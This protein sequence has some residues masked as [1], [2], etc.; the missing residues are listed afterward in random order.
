MKE[1][2]ENIKKD[3]E[4]NRRYW[5][6]LGTAFTTA[7]VSHKITKEKYKS[8]NQGLSDGIKIAEACRELEDGDAHVKRVIF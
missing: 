3:F 1:F 6:L 7:V 5:L 2:I 8:Y 4:E